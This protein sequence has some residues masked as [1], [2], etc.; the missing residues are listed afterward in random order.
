M[1]SYPILSL[2]LWILG[3]L[4]GVY[5][6][7]PCVAKASEHQTYSNSRGFPSN[8]SYVWENR[9]ESQAADVRIGR[10]VIPMRG[11]GIKSAI[12][13]E[14]ER[15]ARFYLVGGYRDI[16]AAAPDSIRGPDA[17]VE[18]RLSFSSPVAN[19]ELGLG[20]GGA[21]LARQLADRVEQ[22]GTTGVYGTFGLERFISSQTS[23]QLG[24]RGSQEKVTGV[25][26]AEGNEIRSVVTTRTVT[27][28][29]TFWAK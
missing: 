2:V 18:T 14:I 23:L 12:G 3:F 4:F 20:G 7:G 13:T 16:F 15:F 5:V 1:R 22:Y 8:S 25:K 29:I 21:V 10:E 6:I 19:V 26:N 17:A 24:I 11:V 9:L 28:G 27:F